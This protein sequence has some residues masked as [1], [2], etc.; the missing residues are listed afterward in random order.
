MSA[1]SG[2]LSRRRLFQLGFLGAMAWAVQACGLSSP[3]G[4]PSEGAPAP[5]PE[6]AASPTEALKILYNEDRQGFYIRYYKPF[7]AVDKASWRLEVA[8][9]VETPRSFTLDEL[10]ALPRTR[11][12]ARMKC[13]ECWSARALW[14]GFRYEE[15]ARL[16]GPQPAAQYLHITCA[17]DY[18][19]VIS[20]EEM[21]HPRALFVTH[22]NGSLL[23]DEY[24]APLRVLLPWKYGYKSPKAITRIEFRQEG[25][26]GYW[27]SVGPYTAEGD[28]RQG[29][30]RPL[31]IGDGREAR[32]IA[33]G[34]ITEY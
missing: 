1:F 21:R 30:D 31:D 5:F 15:L 25:G 10:L 33:G 8:G 6:A 2:R 29:M 27:P 13:V 32:P 34:E 14:E 28:I 12:N 11:L 20:I 4:R 24:G 22:M 26:R 23:P 18:W 7:P 17:D 9:L 19:E 16:V 3:E